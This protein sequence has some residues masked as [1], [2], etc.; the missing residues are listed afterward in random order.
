MELHCTQHGIEGDEPFDIPIKVGLLDS[1]TGSDLLPGTDECLRLTQP[2]Q[3]RAPHI[4][5]LLPPFPIT[6]PFSTHGAKKSGF[7]RW[8][9]P[10]I[11]RS[12]IQYTKVYAHFICNWQLGFLFFFQVFVL[13][14][15][16][17]AEGRPIPSI[18]RD[19]S[20]P[21]KLETDL[22]IG[23]LEYLSGNDTNPFN[24]C[25]GPCLAFLP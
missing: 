1:G 9:L 19:F 7:E 20:A 12:R 14:P 3:V 21:V 15:G 17:K 22:G 2:S 18:L 11:V 13:Q 4:V 25:W 16:Q 6:P 24:R 5:P 10:S 23:D 8:L